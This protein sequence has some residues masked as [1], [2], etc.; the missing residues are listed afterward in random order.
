MFPPDIALFS[1]AHL[2]CQKYGHYFIPTQCLICSGAILVDTIPNGVIVQY[3]D[4]DYMLWK[5]MLQ[6]RVLE[7][8][9]YVFELI[10]SVLFIQ[11]DLLSAQVF[12]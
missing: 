8:D 1:I 3:R 6:V 11:S 4:T 10:E 12:V 2:S 9:T 5:G 7:L